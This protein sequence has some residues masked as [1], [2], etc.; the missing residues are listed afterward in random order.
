MATI[1]LAGGM[2]K[3]MGQDK[4]LLAGGDSTLLQTLVS[5]F[6]GELGAVIVVTRADQSIRLRGARIV[7]DAFAGKGPIG[8]LYAGLLTSSDEKNFVLACD[9]PFANPA[10]ARYLLSR[11]DSHDAVIPMLKHGY[12]PLHAIYH[13][14][15]L[16]RIEANLKI[17]KLKIKDMLD[18][19]N[20]LYVTE[21]DL[22]GIGVDLKTFT[23]INT[24]EEYAALC[25]E[26]N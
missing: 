8:G 22:H 25:G 10:A 3:R 26:S 20:T 18:L 12:E 9:M 21:D 17:D 2:S 1:I 15:C 24:P 5:R 14:S 13:K 4:A 11:S 23:N 16:P 7:Y 6:E 19:A